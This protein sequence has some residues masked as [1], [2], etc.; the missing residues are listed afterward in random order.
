MPGK[1]MSRFKLASIT[2]GVV[3]AVIAIIFTGAIRFW[4]LAATIVIYFVFVILG[5]SFIRMRFF[6]DAVCKGKTDKKQVAI[7]FDDG[8][9]PKVTPLILDRLSQLEV[10]AAFFCL[11][12]Q[13]LSNPDLTRRICDEGH[14]IGNHTF[15]H[16]WWTNFLFG[17]Y[18]FN[19]IEQTQRAIKDA[20]GVSP[21]FFRPPMGLTNP[22]FNSVLRKTGLTMVGW[23]IRSLDRITSKPEVVIEKIINKTRKGS[24]ILLHDGGT[25]PEFIISIILEIVPKL[26]ERGYTFVTL[27]SFLGRTS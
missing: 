22:H 18:L 15:S 3:L 16:G 2:T 27:D 23:S 24:I 19:E 25:N 20:A 26:R 17:R 6:C 4:L 9:D 21:V 1:F 11:G 12:K 14:I 5:V 10:P 8:P 7:T 13:V